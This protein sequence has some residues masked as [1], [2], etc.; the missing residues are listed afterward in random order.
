MEEPHAALAR[1]AAARLTDLDPGLPALTERVLA[2][3]VD[4]APPTR[5]FDPATALGVASFLVSMVAAA[6]PI[7]R[8][9]K[10]DREEKAKG[11][12]EII[13]RRLRITFPEPRGVS[14]AHRDRMIEVVI[15]EL[16]SY[17]GEG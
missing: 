6:W 16:E 15:D 2:T 7:Y 13:A 17:G 11:A 12:R 5:S 8:D 3:G 10:K 1:R 14:A 9:L 4:E